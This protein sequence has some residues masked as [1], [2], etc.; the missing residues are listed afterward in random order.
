M[1]PEGGYPLHRSVPTLACAKVRVQWRRENVARGFPFWF[2]NQMA[3][4]G[5]GQVNNGNRGRL[6]IF[7]RP[8]GP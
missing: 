5:W 1:H 2:Y 8:W 3:L 4:E 6:G 7:D